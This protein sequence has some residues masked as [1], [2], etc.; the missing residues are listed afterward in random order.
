VLVLVTHGN[1]DEHGTEVRT[2]RREIEIKEQ[3]VR[4]RGARRSEQE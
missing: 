3:S 1:H 4:E 2:V